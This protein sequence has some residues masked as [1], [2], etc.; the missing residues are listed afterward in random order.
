[1]NTKSDI[2]QLL[3]CISEGDKNSYNKLFSIIYDELKNIA[4]N[5]L[6]IQFSEHTLSKTDLVH[7]A[8]LK[9]I[10]Q[11][12]IN[13]ND[14]TH[15]YAIAARTMRHLLVDYARKKKAQKRGGKQ[16]P[17]SLNEDLIH[18]EDH[19]DQ[20]IGMD[21]CLSVLME[22]DERIGKIVELRF[23]AGFSIEETASMLKLSTSTVNRDWAKARGWL[24][25][26]LKNE[27]P[28]KSI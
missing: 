27:S 8:Y 22:L 1:M 2:T 25:Q 13:A 26:C 23:Y 12:Q 15:F 11:D 3:Q 9:L 17:I 19:A 7:E 21:D 10:D 6:N 28:D 14:R 18:I 5:Q 4:N 16:Q 24:Y 20:I